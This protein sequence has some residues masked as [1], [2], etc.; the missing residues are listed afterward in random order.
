MK[1]A[2]KR[3]RPAK[4]LPKPLKV[5]KR[6]AR[7]VPKLRLRVLPLKASRL[8]KRQRRRKQLLLAKA[9]RLRRRQSN[10]RASNRPNRRTSRQR[11]RKKTARKSIQ[12]R[13]IPK[14]S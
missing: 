2:E 13:Q 6:A 4:R 3:P 11:P 9:K 1:V 7:T 5:R 12:K 14:D 8:G 10:S